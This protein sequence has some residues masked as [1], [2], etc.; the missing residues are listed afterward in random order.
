M[1]RR[2]RKITRWGRRTSKKKTPF[3]GEYD[4]LGNDSRDDGLGILLV[5]EMGA[6]SHSGQV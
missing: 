6:N 2:D 1:R 3:Y 5:E 4:E